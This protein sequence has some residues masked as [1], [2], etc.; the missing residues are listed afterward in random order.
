MC[1]SVSRFLCFDL[2]LGTTILAYVQIVVGFFGIFSTTWAISNMK[3]FHENSDN[4]LFP[5]WIVIS[6]YV[7]F[8]LCSIIGFGYAFEIRN[9]SKTSIIIAWIII[10]SISVV[11]FLYTVGYYFY[12]F[13]AF[14]DNGVGVGG[15]G[16]IVLFNTILL[17]KKRLT[18]L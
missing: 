1:L 8:P 6:Y 3:F 4:F 13:C 10:Q 11:F 18:S 16:Y 7:M 5:L 14:I 2:K 15:T 17:G 12:Y 9:I